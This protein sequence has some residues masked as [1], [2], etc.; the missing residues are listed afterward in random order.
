[1]LDPQVGKL[2]GLMYDEVDTL[3]TDDGDVYISIHTIDMMS[4]II[5]NSVKMT[6][7]EGTEVPED[8]MFGILWVM[9]LYQMLHDTMELKGNT[10]P[11]PDTP[12]DL[13]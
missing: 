6:I 4:A 8:C 11:V 5:E 9:S 13:T 12:E 3:T 7:L 10:E 2:L 1:M